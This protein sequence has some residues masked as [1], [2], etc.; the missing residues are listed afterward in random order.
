MSNMNYPLDDMTDTASSQKK[1]LQD[2]WQAHQTHFNQQILTPISQLPKQVS[3]PMI[4]H[5]TTW[6]KH[7]QGHYD[8]L[9]KLAEHLDRAASAMNTQDNTTK[10][11]FQ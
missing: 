4:D 11:T 8:A 3:D 7:L 5:L 6:N 10:Q 2:A 1:A 9:Q